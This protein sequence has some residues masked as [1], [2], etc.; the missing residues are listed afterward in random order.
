MLEVERLAELN[1]RCIANGLT[2][3]LV[4][5]SQL[6]DLEPHI[7]G[8]AALQIAASA[9]TDFPAITRKIAEI[10]NGACGEIVLNA[11]VKDIHETA[12]GV[13]I[14]TGS[15]EYYC[16]HLVVCGGLN[17][18]RLARMCGIDVDFQIAPFRG[19]YFDLSNARADIVHHMIYPVPDPELPFLGIHL[20]PMIDGRVTVGPNAVLALAREGYSWGDV[21]I[22]DLRELIFFKGFRTLARQNWRSGLAE[23]RNSIFKDHYLEQCQKYC[24]SLT[25]ADLNRRSAGVRAQA[26]LADGTMVHDFLL[27][28]TRR[29][30]HI[31]N[32]PSPAATSSFAIG[33]HIADRLLS[34]NA[35][36]ESSIANV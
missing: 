30:L 2:P 36:K 3:N 29:T 34:E 25:L 5:R 13:I 1:A 28:E 19:E 18:D 11:E 15:N 21:S 12:S 26:I 32:A 20:T 35:H 8:L 17:A 14:T 23:F 33:E 7:S 10:I 31:C 27:R 9:I 4:D 24:P 6:R 22:R 16:D